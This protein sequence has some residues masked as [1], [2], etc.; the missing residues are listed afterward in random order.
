MAR[1][2]GL[3]VEKW[4]EI[5]L[6]ALSV[7]GHEALKADIL[8]KAQGVSR[9]SFYH[10]FSNV[11]DFHDAVINR[12]KE[13]ATDR[14]ILAVKTSGDSAA[15]LAKLLR[16]SFG[17]VETTERQMRIWAEN[18]PLPRAALSGIDR[19]RVAFVTALLGDMGHDPIVAATR[20]NIIYDCYVG[21][22]LR[23]V[24]SPQEVDRLVA[25]ILQ[26]CILTD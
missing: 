10:H 1:S 12:W 22:A 15:E 7:Q 4:V 6:N 11:T 14:V 21:C 17:K 20:A 19:Q 13:L 2:S 25:E 5:G 18:D 8:S 26:W 16:L 24:P 3:T 23:R 9:G